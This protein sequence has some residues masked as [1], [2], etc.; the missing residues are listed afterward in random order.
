MLG[1]LLR[2]GAKFMVGGK[3]HWR[4]IPTAL[5]GMHL[6]SPRSRM[7]PAYGQMSM[8]GG[9]N[10]GFMNPGLNPQMQLMNP[11]MNPGPYRGY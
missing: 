11:S 1:E 2:A 9:M 4:A 7:N 6:L 3:Y 10:P 5:V 8:Y